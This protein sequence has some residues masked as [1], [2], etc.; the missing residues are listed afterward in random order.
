MH[1]FLVH[2]APFFHQRLS[3]ALAAS[4]RK[5]SFEPLTDLVR[6]LQPL[7]EAFGQRYHL[8]TIER[9]LVFA[10]AGKPF[11]R[12]L[13]RHFAGELLL[14]AAV[15]TP[16]FPIAPELL[17]QFIPPDLVE[18]LHRGS[19]EVTFDCI[20]YRP[21]QA[22]MHDT[23]DVAEL[24]A[25]LAAIDPSAWTTRALTHLAED[26]RDEELAFA[27]QCFEQLQ[28]MVTGAHRQGRLIVCENV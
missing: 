28:E 7:I 13:W 16:D 2:D 3:P 11:H 15:E 8:T 21:D 26:E 6:D 1:L 4:Y 25:T 22:G 19:R 5:R 23:A 27:R 14:Y 12:R 18:R 9:P 20:P 24:A 17:S 10:R